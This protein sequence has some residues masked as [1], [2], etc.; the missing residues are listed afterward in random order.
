LV[1]FSVKV[2][3]PLPVESALVTAFG[4]SLE[5][6]SVAVN[7]TWLGFVEGVVG[8]FEPHPAANV[9]RTIAR[10][11]RRFIVSSP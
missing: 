6:N 4:V 8:V 3:V 5:G 11:A 2:P 9:V 10:T 1:R 7:F